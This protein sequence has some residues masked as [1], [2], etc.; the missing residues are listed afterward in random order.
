MSLAAKDFPL[1][2]RAAGAPLFQSE[3]GTV[4]A[5]SFLAAARRLASGLPAGKPVLNLCENRLSFAL[6]FAAA[7]IAGCRSELSSDR[8]PARVDELVCRPEA[9]AILGDRDAAIGGRRVTLVDPETLFASA[10]AEGGFAI[11]EIAAAWPAADVHTSGSTGVPVAHRKPWGALFARS[12]AAAARFGLE[13][14]PASVVGTVP[15]QHM[16]GFETTVLLAFHTPVTSWCGPAFFPRDIAAALAAMPAPRLLVTTPLQMRA[17][18]DAGLSLPPLAR[19]IS[20]TAPLDPALAERAETRWQTE[21][22]EIFGSTEAGSIASRITTAG[23]IW[24]AY[25]GL[26]LGADEMGEVFVTAP[27]AGKVPLADALALIDATR[28]RL[29]GRRGDVVKLGGKRASLAGLNRILTAI[30]GVEDGVF[31]APSDLDAD[32]T[33]RLLAF[34]VAPGREPAAI[35]AA[36]RREIDP[37]FLPRRVISL[38]RLPRNEFGKLNAAGLAALAGPPAGS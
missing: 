6:G 18:L 22:A 28:F 31:V 36:L 33:A 29:L 14:G 15:P 7:M 27:F 30:E 17:L 12:L 13:P 26:A 37:V 19:V 4:S 9:G 16:Y 25:P 35:L 32:P 23:D 5:G 11:P 8:S 10:E 20:A 38:S 3:R 34:V 1:L 2:R 21:V 24:D